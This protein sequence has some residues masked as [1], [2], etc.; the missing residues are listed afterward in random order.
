MCMKAVQVMFDE[1]LLRRLSDSPETKKS[2][3]SAVVRR[4][5]EHYLQE[6]ERERIAEAYRKAYADTSELD[7]ELEDWPAEG[8]WP[9]E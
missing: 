3:R 4:A 2:G 7:Q 5:V 9:A 1:G 6:R 8:T